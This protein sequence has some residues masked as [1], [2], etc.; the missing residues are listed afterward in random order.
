M[1]PESAFTYG[2]INNY[3]YRAS[4]PNPWAPRFKGIEATLKAQ[5]IKGLDQEKLH[6]TSEELSVLLQDSAVK[7][8]LRKPALG[9]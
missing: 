4:C 3:Q 6:K 2:L 9:G 5:D 8:G 7:L 1:P